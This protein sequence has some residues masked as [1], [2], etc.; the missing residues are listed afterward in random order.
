MSCQ[1]IEGSIDMQELLMEVYHVVRA[2]QLEVYC[3]DMLIIISLISSM[4]MFKI[5]RNGIKCMRSYVVRSVDPYFYRFFML[6]RSDIEIMR[7]TIGSSLLNILAVF[8]LDFVFPTQLCYVSNT[9][10]YPRVKCF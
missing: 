5:S 3:L 4:I 9:H 8:C 2:S 6:A 10:A 1:S 7:Y